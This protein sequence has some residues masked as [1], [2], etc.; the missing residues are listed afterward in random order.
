M[1]PKNGL[2]ILWGKRRHSCTSW[3]PQG[4]SEGKLD[5]IAPVIDKDGFPHQCYRRRSHGEY[6]EQHWKMY[7]EKSY[8]AYK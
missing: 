8:K 5:C 2:R 6:C 1:L 7:I 4:I 3:M